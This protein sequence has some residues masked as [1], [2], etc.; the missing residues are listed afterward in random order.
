VILRRAVGLYGAVAGLLGGYL[1]G[2]A[3]CAVFAALSGCFPWVAA[4]E[5]RRGFARRSSI[6]L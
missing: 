1:L 6:N 2:A 4:F 3:F 5:V